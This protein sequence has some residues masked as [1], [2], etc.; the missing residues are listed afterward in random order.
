MPDSATSASD[1]L[2]PTIVPASRRALVL[3][4]LRLGA[5]GFGGPAALVGYMRRDLVERRKVVATAAS[6][7][8]LAQLFLAAGLLVV[9]VRAWPG[10]QRGVP[11]VGACLGIGA[12]IWLLER[13]LLTT[14]AGAAGDNQLLQI[15][16]FFTKAGAFVF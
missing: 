8:E 1:E 12:L 16:L 4:F 9:V 14:D 11:V 5:L 15:L 7:A 13:S 6:G 10:S 2:P 3:Y